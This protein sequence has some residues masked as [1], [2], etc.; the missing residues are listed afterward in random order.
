MSINSLNKF[1]LLSKPLP[2][3]SKN[4]KK[5]PQQKQTSKLIKKIYNHTSSLNQPQTSQNPA[6]KVK[7]KP[8]EK[9]RKIKIRDELEFYKKNC[10][11]YVREE[12]YRFKPGDRLGKRKGEKDKIGKNGAIFSEQDFLDFEKSYFGGEDKGGDGKGKGSQLKTK[13]K[14]KMLF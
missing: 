10:L 9:K 4:T 2:S 6:K 14:A 13:T 1:L 8:A 12:Q 11:E 3:H 5:T 7:L